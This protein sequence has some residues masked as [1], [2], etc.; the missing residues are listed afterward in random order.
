MLEAMD[1]EPAVLCFALHLLLCNLPPFTSVLPRWQIEEHYFWSAL[2][3]HLFVY[4][5]KHLHNSV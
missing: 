2:T 3:V 4:L 1:S 5:Y